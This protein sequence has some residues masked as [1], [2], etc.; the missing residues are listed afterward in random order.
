[1]SWPT[2]RRYPRTMAEAFPDP[3]RNACAIE[4]GP[5]TRGLLGIVAD[6]CLACLIGMGLAAALVA[7]W[8][9]Q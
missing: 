1:M 2:S 3:V 4:R 6:V 9:S 8:G 5:T 7:W